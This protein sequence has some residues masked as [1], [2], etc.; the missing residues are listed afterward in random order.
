VN[1]AGVQIVYD[2]A[3]KEFDGFRTFNMEEGHAVALL[4]RSSDKSIVGF[5]NKK[6][7]VTIGGA[8]AETKFFIS[9]SS[10]SDDRKTLKLEFVTDDK[11]QTNAEEKLEVKGTLPL[12]LASG[13]A[14]TKSQAFPVKED[15]PIVFAVDAE[16]L[17]TLKIKKTKKPSW[18]DDA[19]EIEI[20]TNINI[21]EFAGIRFLTKD[22]K[23]IK[24]NRNGHS[25]VT[26]GSKANGS[27][28]YSL[29]EKHEEMILVLET[30]KGREEKSVIV[31]LK[32]DWSVK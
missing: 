3:E 9:T 12:V 27:V 21:D 8:K 30:W 32:A 2:S 10:Y 5:D 19:L 4:V 7:S 13:K 23:E 31:D 28:S 14:E 11:V 24:A 16:G 17:P 20:S 6:A 18:G 1:L 15:E 25:W 22:G 29:G 26:N